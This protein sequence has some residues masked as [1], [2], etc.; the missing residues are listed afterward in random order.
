MNELQIKTIG[1]DVPRAVKEFE[2]ASLPKYIVDQLKS[3]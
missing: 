3:T 2:E 1:H